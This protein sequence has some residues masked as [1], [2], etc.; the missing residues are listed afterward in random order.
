MRDKTDTDYARGYDD[1]KQLAWRDLG[2]IGEL[3]D[4]YNK[5]KGDKINVNIRK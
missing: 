1:K 3:E 4:Q 2:D 5:Y